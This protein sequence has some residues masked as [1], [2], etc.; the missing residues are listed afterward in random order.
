MMPKS[1]FEDCI[2]PWTLR[3][4]NPELEELFQTAQE[5][6]VHHSNSPKI[7]LMAAALTITG[8][9]SFTAYHYYSERD[10]D[11]FWALLWSLITGNSGIALEMFIH[12]FRCLRYLRSFF[13]TCGCSFASAYYSAHVYHIPG[14]LP[15]YAQYSFT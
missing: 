6:K 3:F 12:R 9:L 14:M 1:G 13:I 10:F 11:K 2:H 15:G 4:A 7:I 8:T 5:R